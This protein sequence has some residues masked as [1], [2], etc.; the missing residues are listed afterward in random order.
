MK[1]GWKAFVPA[2]LLAF[3]IAI[4]F[5]YASGS[6]ELLPAGQFVLFLY[7]AFISKFLFGGD[8]VDIVDALRI[9]YLSKELHLFLSLLGLFYIILY[10]T[11]N[12][13]NIKVIIILGKS[14]NYLDYLR[15][16]TAKKKTFFLLAACIQL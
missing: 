12:M 9:F 10:F 14:D 11:K 4:T 5:L 2:I 8:N 3:S 13:E 16:K 1:N 6:S 15:F 7:H